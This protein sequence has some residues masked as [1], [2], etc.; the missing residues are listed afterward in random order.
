MKTAILFD[1]D[2]TLLYAKGLGR[3]AFAEAFREAYGIPANFDKVSFVGATDTA[4]VR[5]MAA[6]H[7]ILSTPKQEEHFFIELS[8]RL[9]TALK[10]TPPFVYPGVDKLLNALCE[11]GYVLG[12]VTGNIRATAWAKLLTANL[13]HYFTFG[14]YGCDHSNR[15]T[16]ATIAQARAKHFN[17]QACLLVGDTEKDIQAAHTLQ[18]PALT[19]TASG[20]VEAQTLLNAGADA[21]L[22][23][24]DPL[25]QTLQ[26][27]ETLIHASSHFTHSF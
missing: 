21:C 16:I 22:P 6:H 26:T 9:G 23:S 3:P 13:A 18:L 17:A 5:A 19:V 2:G 24:F 12:V 14:A 20:W 27:I 25:E 11:R 4:V 8:H 10:E 15:N 1:I 7:G